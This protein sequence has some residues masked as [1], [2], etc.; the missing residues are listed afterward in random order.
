M[1]RGERWAVGSIDSIIAA[2]S[3]I[4][5]RGS[6]PRPRVAAAMR[7]AAPVLQAREL[8]PPLPALVVWNGDGGD[9]HC[10]QRNM[11]AI[12]FPA[13]KNDS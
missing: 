12:P 9:Q 2:P 8:E 4:V 6:W 3:R 7:P 11:S 13:I 5:P 10:A 1:I